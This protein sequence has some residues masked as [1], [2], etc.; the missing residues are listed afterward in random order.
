LLLMVNCKVA[1]I[2]AQPRQWDVLVTS[3]EG[4]WMEQG[5]IKKIKW[6]YLIIDE[7]HRI[8]NETSKLSVAVRELNVTNRL[9]ITGSKRI[10]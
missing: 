6:K 3:F 1:N 7:A 4:I 2:Q 10:R 9:L 5:P 8:K